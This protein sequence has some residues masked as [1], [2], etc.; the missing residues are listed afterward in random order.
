MK[1]YIKELYC[2]N[3]FIELKD[4]QINEQSKNFY[5]GSLNNYDFYFIRKIIK[6]LINLVLK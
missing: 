4:Y 6:S 1:Q 2:M 5:K 3:F